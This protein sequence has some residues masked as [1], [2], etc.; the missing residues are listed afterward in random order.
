M[1]SGRS[2]VF[3]S[4]NIRS[5]RPPPPHTYLHAHH[6]Q[7]TS[8]HRPLHLSGGHS[9]QHQ[10]HQRAAPP[11]QC[12]PPRCALATRIRTVLMYK[13]GGAGRRQA[14]LSPPYPHTPTP[15]PHRDARL[16]G[17]RRKPRGQSGAG[18]RPVHR[19]RPHGAVRGAAGVYVCIEVC[20]ERL[21]GLMS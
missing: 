14:T 1:E 11:P 10:R 20:T 7:K 12:E 6:T 2:G 3:P 9:G 15:T 4:V 18:H 8:R 16:G 17:V 21:S 19:Q 13:D 5:R